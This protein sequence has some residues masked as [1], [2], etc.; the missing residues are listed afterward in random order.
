MPDRR[1]ESSTKPAFIDRR[2]VEWQIVEM[3]KA[4]GPRSLNPDGLLKRLARIDA[5]YSPAD[6][7]RILEHVA[8]RRGCMPVIQDDLLEFF[9]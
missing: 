7:L 5:G 9:A 6:I 2:D 3:A 1:S 4:D 8:R